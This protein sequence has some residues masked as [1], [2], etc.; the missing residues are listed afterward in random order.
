MN[1]Q[2]I[3]NYFIQYPNRIFLLD[4]IGAI[5]SSLILML[6]I[7]NLESM[8]GMPSKIVHFLAVFPPF[9]AMYSFSCYFLLKRNHSFFLK[10]ISLLNYFYCIISLLSMINHWQKLTFIGFVYFIIEMFIIAY[11]ARTEW[12]I[13]K[14]IQ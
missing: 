2:K 13:S 11:I 8:I 14:H 5:A 12:T 7:A 1:K 10:G 6:L 9:Y 3:I 4:G